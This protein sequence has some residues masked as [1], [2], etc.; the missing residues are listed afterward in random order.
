MTV[1]ETNQ[2]NIEVVESTFPFEEKFIF[3][4]SGLLLCL[5]DTFSQYNLNTVMERTLGSETWVT[6]ESDIYRFDKNNLNLVSL[7]IKVPWNNKSLH[8][9]SKVNNTKNKDISTLRLGQKVPPF[10]MPIMKNKYLDVKNKVLYCF[11]SEYNDKWREIRLSRHFS[12]FTENKK[13]VCYSMVDPLSI[14]SSDFSKSLD[15]NKATSNDY[16][17]FSIILSI[18]SDEN[19]DNKGVE[20]VVMELEGL[21]KQGIIDDITGIIRKETV[22]NFIDD[23]V[24]YFI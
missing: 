3:D 14:I 1:I 18:Y 11:T 9:D 6:D 22:D 13:I 24:A 19:I 15:S 23:L 12:I 5:A 10:F 21:K 8:F 2:F 4:S 17:I 16:K 7:I 20:N